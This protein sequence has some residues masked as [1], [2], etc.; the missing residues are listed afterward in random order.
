M[1][2]Q[3]GPFFGYIMASAFLFDS[4][5]GKGKQFIFFLWGRS[6]QLGF[7]WVSFFLINFFLILSLNT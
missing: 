3:H 4:V 6:F 2:R 7:F 1:E 5:R